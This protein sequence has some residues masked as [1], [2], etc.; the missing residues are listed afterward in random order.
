MNDSTVQDTNDLVS[1]TKTFLLHWGLPMLAMAG[2]IFLTHPAKTLIWVAALLWMGSACLVNARR[3][4]RTYCYYT[5]PFFLIMTIPVLLHGFQVFSFGH[6]GWK[7]LG[8]VIGVGGG[9][10]WCV[11]EKLLGKYVKS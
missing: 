8:L 2:A 6:E 7:W 9:G 11:S 3:C 4:K 5:G 10:L 1:S